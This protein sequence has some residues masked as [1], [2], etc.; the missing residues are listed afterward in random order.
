[1]K[2]EFEHQWG[3]EDTWYLKLERWAKKQPMPINILAQ[4][5]IEW[6]KKIWIDAKIQNTMREVDFQ[7]NKIVQ[8]WE[9]NDR[10]NRRHV[11]ETG[12][13]GDEGWSIQITNKS[14]EGR[15]SFTV[16]KLAPRSN[17]RRLEKNEGD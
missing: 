6:L 7:S 10:T 16:P 5:M 9:D 3:G 11:L 8:E 4:G 12:V 2:I 14:F 1:M 15:T 13:F 17:E